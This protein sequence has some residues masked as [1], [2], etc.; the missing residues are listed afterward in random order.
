MLRGTKYFDENWLLSGC[1]DRKTVHFTDF[2]DAAIFVKEN[3]LANKIAVCAHNP[4]GSLTAL[5]SLLE[6]PFLFEGAAVHNPIC[7]LVNHLLVDDLSVINR[8][9]GN[10]R[11]SQAV[12]ERVQRYSPYHMYMGDKPVTDLLI[13]VDEE[14]GHQRYHA[15]KL[16]AKLRDIFH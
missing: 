1:G 5:A 10:I 7:D 2:I 16:T 3:E 13:S 6:E 12:Y 4:S 9:F 15:R 14:L 8:E 11:H